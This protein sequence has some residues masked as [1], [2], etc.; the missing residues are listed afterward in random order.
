MTLQ[1]LRF[2]IAVAENGSI[3]AAA[4][5]LY[6]AQSNISS[7]IKS[8]EGELGI[9]I[10]TRSSRGV[11][12]TSD[13]TELLGYAR[14][15]VEQANMLEARYE[16]NE[17]PQ[18]RLAVSAQHYAFSVQAFINVVEAC[19]AQKFEFTMRETTTAQ[20]I[21][22]VRAFRSEVGILYLDDFN[23]RVLEK[24]FADA[25]VSFHPLFNARVHVFVSE[26]H[27]LARKPSICLEDLVPYTRYSFEQGT[28]N[29]FY[30]SEEPFSHIPCAQYTRIGPWNPHQP[31][32]HI[33]RIRTVHRRAFERNAVG[34]GE[35]PA[36][37]RCAHACWLHRAR[38]ATART[39]PHAIPLRAA[40]HHRRC[41]PQRS[42]LDRGGRHERLRPQAIGYNLR[43]PRPLR[44]FDLNAHEL[45]GYLA[46]ACA[47]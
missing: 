11:M 39:N 38:R 9:S 36:Q 5:N 12:L 6:T 4:Q 1:Q 42:R 29:S 31:A 27:P 19:D 18:E 33:K 32:H 26:S 24:A 44:V 47:M 37:R 7:A 17:A 28:S 3:N 2:L 45:K 41:R 20:I 10:F 35:H 43:L 8:L 13:G 16:H 14:Q 15:V 21:D 22:D 23:R 25:R 30:F 40:T 34:H 46:K